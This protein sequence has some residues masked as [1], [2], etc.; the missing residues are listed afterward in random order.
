[1]SDLME[2]R[3]FIQRIAQGITF[4]IGIDTQVIDRD[5]ERVAGTVYKPIPQNGGIVKR[6][7]ES[8][9]YAISTTVDRNSPACLK[10]NQRNNCKEMGYIHCPIVYDNRIVG[11]MGLI[12]YEQEH[13]EKVKDERRGASEFYPEHVRADR[14]EAEGGGR[15]QAGADGAP[16]AG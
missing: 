5:M 6:V 11:V 8:G 7:I 14:P 10:C 15:A 9:E 13:I 1:M 3:E 2:I 12:C 16:Q 4:A